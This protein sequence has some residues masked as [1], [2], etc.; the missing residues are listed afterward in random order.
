MALTGQAKTDLQIVDLS[1]IRDTGIKG[2]VGVLGITERGPINTPTLIGSWLQYTRI[3]GGLLEDNNFPLL[4]RRILEAGGKIR[5][6]RVAHFT[7]ISDVSTISGLVA[8]GDAQ[9]LQLKASSVGE[10]GNDISFEVIDNSSFESGTFKLVIKLKGFPDLTETYI[11]DSV[12][13]STQLTEVKSKSFL[14]GKIATTATPFVPADGADPAV[15]AVPITAGVG[16]LGLGT[17]GD[18]VVTTDF[19]GDSTNATGL[20]AFDNIVD[21]TKLSAPAISDPVFDTAIL[22]YSDVRKDLI[23]VIRTPVGLNSAGIISY[24]NGTGAY[25]HQAFDTWRGI[26]VTGG[27]KINHPVTGAITEISEIGDVLGAMSVK[28]NKYAEWFSFAGPKRGRIRNALGVVYNLGSAARQAEADSVDAHGINAVIEHPSFGVVI[29]GNSTLQK[30]NT[31]LKHANVAELM[32][33]LT[34]ELKPLIE[35]E[36]FEPNDIQTWKTIHRRVVPLLDAVKEQRGIWKYLYQ[37]D[38]DID[39]ISQA[40]INNPDDVDAGRYTFHLFIAPKVAMKYLGVKVVITN[41]GV[42]F[43]SLTV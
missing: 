23:A 8:L 18:P 25:A 21:C 9:K 34:R 41:S 22:A 16:Q 12:P 30:A 26:L 19:I 43:E 27:L 13:T 31:L 36:L 35:S 11:L 28:D 32:I 40:Q 33:Y 39:N 15:P 2:V 10:W 29:W 1:V 6:N 24:R 3:F 37:G 38:Q 4:C 5:V 7:D 14:L 20:H 17:N 42:E